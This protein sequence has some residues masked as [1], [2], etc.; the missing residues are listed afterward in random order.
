MRAAEPLLAP[1][2]RPP[3]PSLPAAPCCVADELR[4]VFNPEKVRAGCCVRTSGFIWLY[5]AVS[6]FVCR[7]YSDSRRLHLTATSRLRLVGSGLL[8]AGV[9]RAAGATRELGVRT[10][11]TRFFNRTPHSPPPP[12]PPQRAVF[13]ACGSPTNTCSACLARWPSCTLVLPHRREALPADGVRRSRRV[14]PSPSPRPPSPCP[15]PFASP[16]LL[17]LAAGRGWPPSRR[18][19]RALHCLALAP[20]PPRGARL[21]E[22]DVRQTVLLL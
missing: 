14:P 10:G 4:G 18:A 21:A 20:L 8:C 19:V 6:G 13:L 11:R 2:R 3:R 15:L 16:A 1:A 7:V 12:S 17:L 22:L 9:P 5:L